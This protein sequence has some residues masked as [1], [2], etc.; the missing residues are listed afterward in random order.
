MRY[1]DESKKKANGVVYSPSDLADFVA[2][3]MIKLQQSTEK[4]VSVL[5][6]AAGQG[7][8]L[9]ALIKDLR[10]CGKTIHAV[11]YETDTDTGRKTKQ[12]L[13]QMFPDVSVDIRIGDF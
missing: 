8:L 7:S 2:A 4:K 9:I 12:Y 5:D 11:G 3:E 6:P 13:S 10:K 1:C